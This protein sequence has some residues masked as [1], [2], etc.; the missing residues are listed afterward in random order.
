MKYRQ[1]R[2]IDHIGIYVADLERSKKFYLAILTALDKVEGYRC[3]DNCFNF[4]EFYIAED[5]SR[6]GYIHLAFQAQTVDQ[7][8]AFYE[9]G[10]K[11]GGI[12]NG[13]PGYREYHDKYYAA[14]LLDPDGNNIEA[15]CDVGAQRSSTSVIVT[16]PNEKLI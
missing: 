2:L 15:T 9:A 14:F 13:A 3:D 6:V 8:H 4:D 16:R 10:L 5:K 12:D 7:V 1:G 11:K